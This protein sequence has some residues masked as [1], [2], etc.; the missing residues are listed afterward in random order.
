MT[1]TMRWRLV[2]GVLLALTVH[3][4]AARAQSPSESAYDVFVHTVAARAREL[5]NKDGTRR[6]EARLASIAD[7]RA[8]AAALDT[9]VAALAQEAPSQRPRAL[10]LDT[11]LATLRRG[12]SMATAL[13]VEPGELLVV[14]VRLIQDA[15]G[16]DSVVW[17]EKAYPLASGDVSLRLR[18]PKKWMPSSSRSDP[19][20]AGCEQ[21]TFETWTEADIVQSPDQW[22]AYLAEAKRF[23]PAALRTAHL[24]NVPDEIVV[25]DPPDSVFSRAMDPVASTLPFSVRTVSVKEWASQTPS[26][27]DGPA[28]R[29]AF[30]D[31]WVEISN[32]T[33]ARE[34][35]G[36]CALLVQKLVVEPLDAIV[37]P[38]RVTHR[39]RLLGAWVK[40]YLL[41][42][43]PLREA[44]SLSAAHVA[45]LD[46]S[47]AV[48]TLAGASAE[49]ESGQVTLA[50]WV[51]VRTSSGVEGWVPNEV[52]IDW[53]GA[54]GKRSQTL[55]V[56]ST[57][58]P[59]SLENDVKQLDQQ[60]SLWRT[61]QKTSEHPNVSKA[62]AA[63]AQ[64]R[65]SF[66]YFCQ[67]KA[68]LEDEVGSEQMQTWAEQAT[69]RRLHSGESAE[70]IDALFEQTWKNP[71]CGSTSAASLAP[72]DP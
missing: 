1:M 26:R 63:K 67:L 20:Q 30:Q 68:R 47:E 22:A 19:V 72:V 28:R 25:L 12:L 43:M 4:S 70:A 48:E 56:L 24:P 6:W 5:P 2:L 14:T 27:S 52:S 40:P 15:G 50:S 29:K 21:A 45:Q 18:V 10:E 38:M 32:T 55:A 71:A 64:A 34:Y 41:R 66:D 42:A 33:Y 58:R 69:E 3:S 13:G 11:R 7:V 61:A 8:V 37:T 51:Q 31:A 49:Q 44:P 46:R 54:T 23:V 60:A 57:Q 36:N 39:R 17:G 35:R 9:V 16:W 59:V 65:T 53:Y 62:A